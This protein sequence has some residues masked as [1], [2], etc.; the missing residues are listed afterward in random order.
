[1]V[2]RSALRGLLGNFLATFVSRNSDHDGYWL[3]GQLPLDGE[4]PRVDLLGAPLVGDAPLATAARLAIQRL[5]EQLAKAGVDPTFLREAVLHW[6]SGPSAHLGLHGGEPSRGHDVEFCVRAVTDL[7][8]EFERRQRV[9][10]APHD[11]AKE[12]RSTRWQ[13]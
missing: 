11:P 2:R 10:V 9:F 13:G 3:L 4:S 12:R 1:M 8:R 5:H 7:G 6:S